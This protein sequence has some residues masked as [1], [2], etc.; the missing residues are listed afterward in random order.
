MSDTNPSGMRPEV[1]DRELVLPITFDYSG[2]R[3]ESN[4][5]KKLWAVIL[6]V[7]ALLF[8]IG[9]M[10]SRDLAWFIS[11]PLGLLVMFVFS[12]FIRFVLL[13]EKKIRSDY[14]EIMDDDQRLGTEEIW[15]IYNVSPVYPYICRFRNGKSGIFVRLTKDVILGKYADAEYEHYEAIGDAYNIAGASRVQIL[16]VDYMVNVGTDERLATSFENLAT[17][18]N[19]DVKDILTEIFTYQ[20]EQMMNAVTTYDVYAFMWTGSDISAWNTITKILAC[21]LDANYRGYVILNDGELRELVKA[22]FN[23]EE[24]SV[25]QASGAAFHTTLSASI[26][27]IEVVHADGTVE[28]I[29][30]TVQ[31]KKDEA[32]QRAEAAK[33]EEKERE[34]RKRLKKENKKKRKKK[35]KPNEVFDIFEEEG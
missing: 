13:D 28:K 27:P 8:G 20:Q 18:S 15:G 33:A 29:N 3:A 11:I 5:S 16:H 7:V 24:F 17:V 32:A 10:R 12:L 30:K 6:A 35:A 26:V 14:S 19:P 2:G 23:L 31:E 4:K 34:R 9:V 1:G 22:V 25:N 21:F